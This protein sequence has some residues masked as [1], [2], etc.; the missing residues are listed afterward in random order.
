MISS[1]AVVFNN[2][3]TF[4]AGEEITFM[5]GFQVTEGREFIAEI[6]PCISIDALTEQNVKFLL[7]EIEKQKGVTKAL[8]SDC[9]LDLDNDNICDDVDDC[10]D[11]D[12]DGY[13]IGG[14]CKGPDCFDADD[15]IPS[16]D[17][18]CD[19]VKSSIDCNDTDGLGVRC[20]QDN[21]GIRDDIDNCPN[22]ANPN[23]T[24]SNKN[25][26]GD[27]CDPIVPRCGTATC[28]DGDPCTIGDEWDENCNCIGTLADSDQD[29]V[30]D[31][32]DKCDGF[33]DSR[34][35]DGD[36]TPDG[37]D[38]D[39]SCTDCEAD[40]EGKIT[41]CW[42]PHIR[43]NMKT[44]IG[45]CDYLQKFFDAEGRIEDQNQCGPC[46]CEMIDDIDSD[47]DGVCDRKDECPSN[48][49]LSQKTECGCELITEKCD[50]DD[51]GIKNP[52]DNCTFT[53]NAD[54]S[55][56]DND[57][58]GD[59][60]DDNACI[61]GSSCDDGNPCTIND[62][63]N[64]DCNCIG[65]EGDSDLDGV[66]D[67]LDKCHGFKDYKDEDK[68]G[69]PDGCDVQ[70]ACGGCQPLNDGTIIICK[71]DADK[72][73]FVNIRG[74]CRDLDFLYDENGNFKSPLYSC[75]QCR[76]ELIGKVDRDGDGKCDDL[77]D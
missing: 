29:G 77:E 31:Y 5:S 18:D 30:C 4:R 60:C 6:M 66:C 23:Q 3:F 49:A 44:V 22:H 67:A 1:D 58:I 15:K 9:A 71:L 24:D 27:A 16:E 55:D 48:P 8:V 20:D 46:K 32:F 73:D 64:S 12:G 65:T 40:S 62:K 14:G 38:E 68:D 34:D 21:D 72:K 70:E 37:C 50:D 10:I 59:V 53:P 52:D 2:D 63:Y 57:G 26:K 35:W 25:G 61:I 54:Q 41:L 17:A 43:D 7:K 13:G 76:C 11:L 45:S 75:G 36:G 69:I 33:D 47:G 28:D 39:V 51:D 74:T 56:L 19:G 42:I